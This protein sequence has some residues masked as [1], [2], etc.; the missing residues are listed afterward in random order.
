ME[1]RDLVFLGLDVAG[2]ACLTLVFFI[3]ARGSAK[4]PYCRSARVRSSFPTAVDKLLRFIYLKPYRCQACRKRFY[5]RRRRRVM[6]SAREN[7]LPAEMRA[8]AVGGSGS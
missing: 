6:S 2:V 4:C 3:V 5:A 8:K 7:S 1:I